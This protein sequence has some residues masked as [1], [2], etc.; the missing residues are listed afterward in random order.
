MKTATKATIGFVGAASVVLALALNGSPGASLAEEPSPSET[1]TPSETPTPT[2]T[3]S[4]TPT[5][6]TPPPDPRRVTS[7]TIAVIENHGRAAVAKKM[8]K[9]TALGR[10]FATGSNAFAITHPSKPNYLVLASGSLQGEDSNRWA[11]EKAPALF[12]LAAARGWGGGVVKTYAQSM[13]SDN[14]KMSDRK[15][16]VWHHNWQ[17]PFTYGNAG[18]PDGVTVRTKR[19]LCERY[20]R[21]GW[22]SRKLWAND[23][24][25]NRLGVINMVLPDNNHNWH[26]GPYSDAAA[27]RSDAWLAARV[28]EFLRSPD[29]RAGGVF[30]IT[31]DEARPS[32]TAND[33]PLIVIH[34]S[35]DGKHRAVGTYMTLR[36]IH[37]FMA[38]V[39]HVK[40]GGGAAHLFANAFGLVVA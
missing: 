10:R 23:V 2:A 3:P 18:H 37:A 38:E 4:P 30:I 16:Y 17:V 27:A 35:L 24:A 21:D 6:T 26:N 11:I 34:K 20:N 31:A 19:S 36:T 8:P 28:A 29:Y 32:S 14:C 40:S 1:A 5:P 39:A 13:G 33:V 7:V 22:D 12:D 15:P 25:G 9:I